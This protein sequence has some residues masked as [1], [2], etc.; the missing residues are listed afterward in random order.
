LALLSSPRVALLKLALVAAVSALAL[1]GVAAVMAATIPIH[2][3]GAARDFTDAGTGCGF[4]IQFNGTDLDDKD[5]PSTADDEYTWGYTVTDLK[6]EGCP[7]LS[8]WVLA[9]CQGAFDDFVATGEKCEPQDCFNVTD[10]P[11][12]TGLTGVKWNNITNG[13]V[14]P[15]SG[16]TFTFTLSQD[17]PLD[18]NADVG[19]KAGETVVSGTIEGPS[20]AVCGDG[21]VEAP[22]ECDD[23]NLIDGDGCSST[24]QIEGVCGDGVV[25]PGEQCDDDNLVDGDG[26]S[27]TCRLEFVGGIV[28]LLVGGADPPARPGEASASSWGREY[29]TLIAAVTT[30]A[31]VGLVAGAS[32]ARR[33]LS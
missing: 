19:F 14:D 27:S 16:A 11:G 6:P 17:F 5:T 9:L 29:M 13:F 18:D 22:E 20:C 21:V 1:V 15:P 10:D 23:G 26:C 7:D 28:D 32:Y 3:G 2:P 30:A 24:C 33:R 4:K 31:V 12:T 25:D 8:H